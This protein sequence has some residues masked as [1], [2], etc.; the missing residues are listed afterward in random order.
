MCQNSHLSRVDYI[1]SDQSATDFSYALA[2]IRRGYT[3]VEIE[4]RIKNERLSQKTG[5]Q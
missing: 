5:R 4:D 1:K 3:D 2:L